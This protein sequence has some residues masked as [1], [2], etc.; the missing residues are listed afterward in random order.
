VQP[1]PDGS[2]EAMVVDISPTGEGPGARLE[3][4]ILSGAHKGDV[5]M[6]RSPGL[7]PDDLNLLGTSCKVTV[8]AGVP[9]VRLARR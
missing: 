4:A 5:V 7:D 2:Y 6:V 8:V 1:L 9:G 3:L